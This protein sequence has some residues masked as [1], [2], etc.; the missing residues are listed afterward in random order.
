MYYF[1]YVLK[2]TIIDHFSFQ[3]AEITS[4]T[5]LL[6]KHYDTFIFMY[7]LVGIRSDLTVKV[8]SIANDETFIFSNAAYGFVKDCL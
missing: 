2:Q 3:L 6:P 7:P 1:F 5:K 8:D 4:N